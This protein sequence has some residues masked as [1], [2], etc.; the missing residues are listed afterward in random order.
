MVCDFKLETDD[1]KIICGHKVVLASASPYFLAM[2][3]NCEEKNQY[4]AIMKRLD[5]TALQLLVNFIYSGEITVTENNLQV[6]T[7]NI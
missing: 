6:I 3:K 7:N 4:L 2:F 1:G 5:S